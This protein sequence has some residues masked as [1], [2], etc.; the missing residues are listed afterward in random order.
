MAGDPD[1]RTEG[2]AEARLRA[3]PHAHN[4][5]T[6]IAATAFMTA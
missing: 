2:E 1:V 6:A 4:K 5:I 3:E